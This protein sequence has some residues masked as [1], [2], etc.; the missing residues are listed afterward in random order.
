M[1]ALLHQIARGAAW[2]LGADLLGRLLQYVLLWAAARS[3]GVADFG[4]FTFALSVG[5]MLAQVADFGLQLFVQRELARLVIPGAISRPYFS[6]DAAASRLIGGGLLIKAV[7]SVVSLAFMVV[8]VAL[9]PV[10]NKGALLLVGLS[11][12]LG[13]GLEYLSY[14]FRALGRLKNE[15]MATLLAR[16]VNLV[17]GVG[18]LV[19]GAGVWGLAIA[20]NIAMLAA[21]GF[22]YSR[23]VSYVRPAWHLDWGYWRR[24]LGQ[25]TAIGIGVVFSIISFRVDNLLIPPIAGREALGLYNVAY[26]LFEPSQ[27][28]PGAL[29]AATFPLISQAALGRERTS[30]RKLLAHNLTLLLGLGG[31]VTLFLLIFAGPV[32]GLLYGEEYALS[33]PILQILALACVPMF[34]NYAL[35]HVLIAMDRPRLYATFTAAVIFVNLAVNLALLPV[36]GVQGAAWATVGTEFALFVL[37]AWAV[38]RHINVPVTTPAEPAEPY[39]ESP[40]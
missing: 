32:I 25:P 13:T 20:G 9:E 29:L 4:D 21:I 16:S 36:I 14:C 2:K 22:N 8:L 6:D 23:L 15:A 3:L 35:T 5:L 34:L 17:L 11:M 12:V 31:G 30:L 27:V 28:L 39:W 19:A 26:K 1:R 37:C 7:L 33:V 10:G 38:A 18:L 24:V 40:L